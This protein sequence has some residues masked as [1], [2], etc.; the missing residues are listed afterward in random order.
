QSHADGV[1]DTCCILRTINP[2]PSRMNE[3]IYLSRPHMGGAELELVKDV[4]AS[5][6]VAPLGPHVDAFEKELAAYVGSGH[7]AALSSGTSAIHLALIIIGVNPGE[8][9][10]CSSFTFSA[11]CNPIRYM[12]ANPVFVDSESLTWN[13]DPIH[14]RTAILARKKDTARVHRVCMLYHLYGLPAKLA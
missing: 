12:G 3:R 6:W 13:M 11:S 9:V 10:L 7:C 1:G 14:L 8:E 2:K 4:F 5:N